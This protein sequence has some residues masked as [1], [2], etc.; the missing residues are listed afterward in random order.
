MQMCYILHIVYTVGYRGSVYLAFTTRQYCR[1][2]A[3]SRDQFVRN[4]YVRSL[5]MSFTY[6]WSRVVA[7][8]YSLGMPIIFLSRDIGD[9]ESLSI[10]SLANLLT[11]GLMI[12]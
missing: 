10:D 2:Q 7:P 12:G 1:P 3:M 4:K 8:I 11:T 6:G 5:S 9:R